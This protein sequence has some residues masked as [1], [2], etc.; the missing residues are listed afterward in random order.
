MVNGVVVTELGSK[1][2]PRT[3]RVEVNGN[4]IA[5]EQD[6]VYLA[7]NKP[8]G[9]V[10]SCQQ[11]EEKVVLDLIDIPKRVYPIGRLD[12]D[13]TGLLILTN[14]GRLHHRLLHPSFDHEKEYEV[15]L[16]RPI[17]DGAL[18]A[19]A[20]GLPMMGTK[21]RPAEVTR[22]SA[23]RFRIVLKE[24]KNRQ[25]RR[26][27]RKVGHQVARLKRIRMAN[28]KLGKLKQGAWRYLTPKEKEG[29]LR[30]V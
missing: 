5:I 20:K 12:K 2:D 23:R 10:T 18:K 29:L 15:T 6:L 14:D 30:I 8:P 11:A 17:P 7:L 1:V 4:V 21:T 3:D 22:I 28:I 25:I 27:V 24:G 9:L 13:S 26:M 19:L 16:V